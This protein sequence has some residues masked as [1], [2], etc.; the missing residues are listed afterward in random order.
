[1][2]N[3]DRFVLYVNK[4]I[5]I[6]KCC[7]FSNNDQMLSELKKKYHTLRKRAF[8]SFLDS[9][10]VPYI[11]ENISKEKIYEFSSNFEKNKDE[12]GYRELFDPDYLMDYLIKTYGDVDVYARNH[13]FEY[14]DDEI[15]AVL[16]TKK[17]RNISNLVICILFTIH[18]N[19]VFL[20]L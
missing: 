19:V 17:A 7:K 1:M 4:V 3:K 2:M 10:V 5:Y 15:L 20:L 12:L 9:K 16:N 6:L 18:I 8:I 14:E 13:L 11:K